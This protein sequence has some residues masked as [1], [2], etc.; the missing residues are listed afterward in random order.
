[1]ALALLAEREAGPVDAELRLGAVRGEL[2]RVV[3]PLDR[4]VHEP[5]RC[6]DVEA[7]DV[8]RRRTE[9]GQDGGRAGRTRRGDDQRTHDGSEN[10]N[11]S[12]GREH[13][14][15]PAQVPARG[16]GEA[17]LEVLAVSDLAGLAGSEALLA[18]AQPG[19]DVAGP[20]GLGDAN[21]RRRPHNVKR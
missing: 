14:S 12:H 13:T 1:R 20:T 11:A 10:E 21:R 18:P 2:L 5:A 15:A 9:P 8:P 16:A 19:V 3:R 6:R 4:A 7:P 17:V